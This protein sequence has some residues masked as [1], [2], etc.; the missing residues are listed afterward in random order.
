MRH[1]IDDTDYPQQNVAGVIAVKSMVV[2]LFQ[3]VPKSELHLLF[4][5]LRLNLQ[6]RILGSSS[7]ELVKLQGK[8][9]YLA[10]LENFFTSF[11]K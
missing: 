11:V 4:T 3:N 9:E 7:D 1:Q 2:D 8:L 10:E 6:G 5:N